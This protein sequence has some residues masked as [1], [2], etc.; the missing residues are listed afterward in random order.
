ML[1]RTRTLLIVEDDKDVRA[2]FAELFAQEGYSVLESSNG[3]EAYDTLLGVDVKVDAILTD[4]R[5]PIMNG[6]ELAAKIKNNPHFSSTPVVLLSA[7]P[8]QNSWEARRTF[9]A[10]LVKPCPLSLLLSTIEAVQPSD[11]NIALQ[12]GQKAAFR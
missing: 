11:A 12:G 1:E 5:M 4:L 2:I 7:T 10:L 3:A 8:M 9:D 6:L